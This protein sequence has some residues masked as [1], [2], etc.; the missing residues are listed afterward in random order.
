[1]I[2]F[3]EDWA[4]YPTAIP[5]Y[6]TTNTSFLDLVETYRLQ[7]VE[8]RD[9]IL[10]L[11]QPELVGVDP[12]DPEL[13]A[14]TK[15][16]IGHEVRWNPWYYLREIA[17]IP[18]DG[19]P[20][21]LVV[22]AHR[23]LISMWWCWLNN[24]DYA[25]IMPRQCGKSVGGNLI[26]IWVICIAGRN[27]L[28]QYITQNASLRN[29]NI[30]RLKLYRDALPDYLNCYIK[31]V[32]ADN[33]IQ[34]TCK[35]YS[36][37]LNTFIAQKDPKRADQGG[38]GLT[39]A[40]L[41]ID[42]GPF[43]ANIHITLGA[44]LGSTTTARDLAEANGTFYGNIYTTT[45]GK[46]DEE[47][48]EYMYNL[49]HNGMYWSEKL[50]DCDNKF[51]ARKMIKANSNF[52]DADGNEIDVDLYMVNG[53]FTAMQVG[54]SRKWL[55]EKIAGSRNGKAAAQ[56][57]FLNVWTMGSAESPLE[58]EII[59]AIVASEREPLW[60]EKSKDHYLMNWYIPRDQIAK[61]M[62][63]GHYFITLDTGNMS[64][65]DAN[66]LHI[67]DVKS[68]DVIASSNVTDGSLTRY[69]E[70]VYNL[71]HMYQ[72]TTLVIENASSAPGILDYVA[73]RL[74]RNGENPFRR[75]YN[76]IIQ[77][78]NRYQSIYEEFKLRDQSRTIDEVFY[79][80]HKDKFGFKTNADTR[81]TLYDIILRRATS[82]CGHRIKD[83]T[84]SAQ[85]RGLVF[86]NNRVDHKPGAH[87]DAV[88]SWLMGHY[89]AIYGINTSYYGIKPGSMYSMVT[90]NATVLSIE[91][92]QERDDRQRIMEQIDALKEYMQANT[93]N[94]IAV[95]TAK[96]K[97][98]HLANSLGED[99]HDKVMGDIF[100]PDATNKPKVGGN[101]TSMREVRNRKFA[102]FR[103]FAKAA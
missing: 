73:G 21:P 52:F 36:N 88:I 62:S 25:N 1:M 80:K 86:R 7:G 9:F 29:D 18:Q 34:F 91:E 17:R 23:A 42:E 70:W 3:Q 67:L 28:M 27:T 66:A 12:F 77:E 38:R 37:Y 100:N 101:V 60:V 89:V 75:I 65:R 97:I 19:S 103:N 74:L 68:M 20:D 50:F 31:N 69:S 82:S 10:A 92:I 43:C 33:Q 22:R 5:D 47:E 54:K 45:A 61:V 57:D 98:G 83:K 56:R 8:N 51:D 26:I 78:P 13:D 71:L 39:S 35:H 59:D 84:L 4:K 96:I 81:S 63:N 2:L 41:L 46:R 53:T 11:Y 30:K 48:G 44:A 95:E 16:L 6:N 79:H 15:T 99:E 72:N 90:D 58:Q 14:F 94:R 93:H 55:K 32:D 24:F 85:I 49:I 40:N 87:D 102:N 76:R 64:G